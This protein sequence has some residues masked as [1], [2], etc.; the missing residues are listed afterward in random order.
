MSVIDYHIWDLRRDPDLSPDRVRKLEDLIAGVAH[1]TGYGPGVKRI[2]AKFGDDAVLIDEAYAKRMASILE[3]KG[4]FFIG[5]TGLIVQFAPLK[6]RTHHTRSAFQKQYARSDWAK[7]KSVKKGKGSVKVNVSDW[8]KRWPDLKSPMEL[9]AFAK[10]LPNGKRSIN[11]HSWSFDL[12][13][14]KPGETYSDAQFEAAAKLIH[15]VHMAYDI[16]IDRAHMCSHSDINPLDR[17]NPGNGLWD[18]GDKWD[19]D[20]VF[21]RIAELG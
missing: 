20:R 21:A 13:A 18:P 16:P 10:K 9:P 4:T 19:W 12:L 15:H 5:R 2:D 1:T 6:Y 7:L 3:Y 17:S 14:H 11:N 8:P